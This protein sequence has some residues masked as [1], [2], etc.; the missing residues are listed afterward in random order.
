VGISLELPGSSYDQENLRFNTLHKYLLNKGES[1]AKIPTDRFNIEAWKGHNL[2]QIGT[3]NGTFLKHIDCFDNVEFGMSAKDA[4]AMAP[5]TRKL[6][7]HCFLALYDSGI[8]YRGRNIGCFTAGSIYEITSVSDADEFDAEGSFAGAPSMIANRVS[9]HLDL[10]GP[11]IASDT[12]CSSSATALHLAVNA[13]MSEDCEAAVVGGCQLNHRFADWF[14]YSQG[15]VLSKDGKCKP[16]D[17]SADGFSR[18][19][20][21]VAIVIKPLN[22]ALQDDDHIYGVASIESELSIGK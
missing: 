11:S 12:A 3:E 13:I 7:E 18:G 1:Y 17:A 4:R 9:F 22:I 6:I 8:N 14:N 16:F 2:G 20:G 15:H 19:E 21:V 5:S 10:T